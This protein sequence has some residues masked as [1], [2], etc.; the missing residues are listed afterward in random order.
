VRHHHERFDGSG[1]PDGLAGEAIPL[2]ARIIA[3]VDTFDA[4]TSRRSYRDAGGVERAFAVL[5]EAAGS[6]LDPAVVTA[7]RGCYAEV[8][9]ALATAAI[10][11]EGLELAPPAPGDDEDAARRRAA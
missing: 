3:V 9:A 1:Y 7:F 5:E 2:I 8:A 11:P 6:Q 10:P 4:V